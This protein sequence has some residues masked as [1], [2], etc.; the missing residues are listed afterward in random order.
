MEGW[1]QSLALE[2]KRELLGLRADGCHDNQKGVY[3]VVSTSMP[4]LC[5]TR[6]S[7]IAASKGTGREYVLAPISAET[8][9][10]HILSLQKESTRL[11]SINDAEQANLATSINW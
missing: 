9:I 8:H 2:G 7:L 1:G 5:R 11:M 10:R 6:Q 4:H 3:P